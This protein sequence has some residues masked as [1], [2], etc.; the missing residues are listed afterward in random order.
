MFFARNLLHPRGLTLEEDDHLH[1][2]PCE[3]RLKKCFLLFCLHTFFVCLFLLIS[4]EWKSLQICKVSDLQFKIVYSNFDFV[5]N[6]LDIQGKWT[7]KENKKT[8]FAFQN[9]FASLHLHGDLKQS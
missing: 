2:L 1:V 8:D 5:E 9:T 3:L 4:H 6:I 7:Q